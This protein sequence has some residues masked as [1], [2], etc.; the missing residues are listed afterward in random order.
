MSILRFPIRREDGARRLWD[1][2]AAPPAYL[3]FWTQA[4]RRPAVD[5]AADDIQ[6]ALQAYRCRVMQGTRN[7]CAAAP[8]VGLR[9]VDFELAL[10][11]EPADHALGPVEKKIDR[12]VDPA[13]ARSSR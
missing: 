5:V 11:A 2:P 4:Y 10:A 7:G 13:D 9:I 12:G 8:A 6:L 1:S 3:D